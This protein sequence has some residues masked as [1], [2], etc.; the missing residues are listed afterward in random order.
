MNTADDSSDE[1]ISSTALDLP[2]TTVVTIGNPNTGKSSLFNLLTG[3][4]Q[5]VSNFPGVTVDYLQG[6]CA[7]DGEKIS[8]VDVPGT[9]SIAAQSPDEL[10]ALNVLLGKVP[11]IGPPSAVVLV[12]DATN[13]RRNLFLASQVRE[14]PLRFV[15]AL[16]MTDIAKQRNIDINIDELSSALDA[17]VVPLVASKGEGIERL[18][19]VL[20]QTLATPPP[21]PVVLNEAHHLEAERLALQAKDGTAAFHPFEIYRALIDQEGYLEKE[22]AQSYPIL[23]QKL[24]DSRR[25]LAGGRD[26]TTIEARDRYSWINSKIAKIEKREQNSTLKGEIADRI[27]N[28]PIYGSLLF[29][30]VMA[31]VFQSVF[32]WANPLME[33]IDGTTA[34]L[35]NWVY[36]TFGDS[37]FTSFIC[38]L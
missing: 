17:P 24:A 9:Y 14:L 27:I 5:K 18:K 28:H 30:L 2:Q 26:L 31:V 8:L 37:L 35:G 12:L 15:I 13:L 4:N 19:Q 33:Q 32:T 25:E 21:T 6:D 16:T 22:I 38:Y 3:L 11:D 1:P 36:T 20:A 23:A 29:V 10:V 7:L 34:A